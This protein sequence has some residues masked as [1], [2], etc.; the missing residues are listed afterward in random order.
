M[1]EDYR[2]LTITYPDVENGLGCRVTVWT[3][4]CSHHCLG[5]HNPHTWI[6]GQGKKLDDPTVR[7]KIFEAV[8][9]PYIKGIIFLTTFPCGPD[10]LVNELMLRKIKEYVDNEK[11]NLNMAFVLCGELCGWESASPKKKT[12]ISLSFSC[13]RF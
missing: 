12:N 13:S 8:D 6:Y 4:G 7:Q 10:S 2:V 11:K 9:K 5:C 1:S 3:S